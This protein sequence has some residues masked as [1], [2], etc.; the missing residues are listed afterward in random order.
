MFIKLK[1]NSICYICGLNRLKHIFGLISNEIW[2]ANDCIVI[3][4]SP[5]ILKVT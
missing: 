2:L 4:S 5:Y 1:N 3:D